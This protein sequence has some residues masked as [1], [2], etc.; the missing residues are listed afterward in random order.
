MKKV[1]VFGLPG[2]GK[3]TFAKTLASQMGVP[4]LHLD[5]VLFQGG[6][7]LPLGEFRAQTAA[8]TCGS[9]WVAEG[10]FHDLADVTWARSDVVVWLDYPLRVLY[11]RA[12]RRA[13][14]RAAGIEPR[15]GRS[16]K[17]F[18]SRRN[19]AWTVTR[20]YLRKRP[21]YGRDLAALEGAGVVR[22]RSPRRAAAWLAAAGL[23]ERGH[24]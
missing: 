1:T 15:A 24:R 23:P 2:S 9:T 21:G 12:G 11:W 4:C 19:L 17:S 22:F 14:R 10:N 16:R 3:T 5:K 7:P 13:L 20:K 18:F 6:K 8:F